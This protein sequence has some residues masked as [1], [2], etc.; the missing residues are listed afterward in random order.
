MKRRLSILSF[1]CLALCLC[2]VGCN[3]WKDS[4]AT[5]D[6]TKD[7]GIDQGPLQIVAEGKSEYIIVRSVYATEEE[8]A[9]ADLLRDGIEE[10][11]GVRLFLY[12]DEDA[13]DEKAICIGKVNRDSAHAL[14]SKLGYSE[15]V[16]G[17]SGDDLVICG[18]HVAKTRE[19]VERFV[20]DYVSK[21][22]E[23]LLI[24]RDLMVRETNPNKVDVTIDGVSLYDYTIVTNSVL[25]DEVDKLQ[26]KLIEKYD[27]YL[28]VRDGSQKAVE[29]EIIIGSTISR[30]P[31]DEM[32]E[33]LVRC[34]S[35][36]GLIYFENGKL[37]LIGNNDAS[38]RDAI[39]AFSEEYLLEDQTV[40][41]TFALSMKNKQ[42]PSAGTEYVLMGYNV[43]NDGGESGTE[44]QKR[45]DAVMS[46]IREASPDVFGINECTTR[47]FDYFST[48]LAD[49]YV[50]IGELNDPDGQRWRNAIFYRKDK[51]D[52]VETKTQW[53]T[54]TPN[55]IS[56]VKDGGQYRIMTHAVL[57]DKQTGETFVYCNTHMGFTEIER[58][59]QF[60]YL[61]DL[62]SKLDYPLLMTGDFNL[63]PKTEQIQ[64]IVSAGY[65]PS[66]ELTSD[67]DTS[68]TCGTQVIDFCFVT[69][70]TVNVMS[71]D[72]L[73]GNVN[74]VRPSDHNPVVVHFRLR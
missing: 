43:M 70:E 19:T 21:A 67:R 66:Y 64:S 39:D 20:Q 51:F 63:G 62:I 59:Y 30:A 3:F 54:D 17:V 48:E 44:L 32:K 1:V 69:P 61:I 34:G 27:L 8:I 9:I 33:S 72:V 5:S 41:G 52:L 49:E 16:I 15:S 46:R 60:Q 4:D 13:P 40:D 42:T 7:Q 57:R 73:A 35:R 23:T 28:P 38:V 10:R 24:E 26:E 14:T 29:H 74:G 55:V 50:G 47:W 12:N 37:W 58:Q 68:N 45:R 56:R 31:S 71:Y 65:V 11:F 2:M 53:L 18:G 36:K 6:G 22:S 25:M